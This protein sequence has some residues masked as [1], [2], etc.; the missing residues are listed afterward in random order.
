MT[1]QYPTTK[2]VLTHQIF[3]HDIYM[4]CLISN[5][6]GPGASVAGAG[7]QVVGGVVEGASEAIRC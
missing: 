1:P 3:Y 7:Y 5:A 2:P 4:V 6:T